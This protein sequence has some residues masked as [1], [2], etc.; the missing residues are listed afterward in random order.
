[1]D[2]SIE[3]NQK[4]SYNRNEL[5]EQENVLL[6]DKHIF[7]AING[8]HNELDPAYQCELEYIKIHFCGVVQTEPTKLTYSSDSIIYLSG[9]ISLIKPESNQNKLYV[10]KELS[11]NYINDSKDYG[12]INIGEV[13]INIHN[14]GVYFRKLFPDNIDYF[15]LIKNAHEFQTLTESNK[16]GKAFRT[17]IYLTDVTQLDNNLQFNLLRCSTNLDGPTD[18][19]RDID[20]QILHKVNHVAGSMFEKPVRLNH[21]LAQIYENSIHDK[22]GKKVEKKAVIK[23]HSDKT[24]DMPKDALI[25]FTT[26]YDKMPSKHKSNTDLFDIC[27]KS[28]SVLT[29]LYFRLKNVANNAD[30]GLV[31]EFTVTLYPNS[32]FIIPLSTNRLYTHEIRPS[33]LSVDKIPTRLGYVIRCSNTKAIFKDGQTYIHKDGDLNKL[34]DITCDTIQTIRNLYFTENVSTEIVDYPTIQCSMNSGDYKMPII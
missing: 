21:V 8:Q 17:G 9:D 1:M 4:M 19:F 18:N 25:A 32:V 5:Y 23:A 12:I 6:K 34:Q 29:R 14:V 33:T 10:V 24:K 28:T 31:K 16:D 26:F 30:T 11:Y 27:Y 7:I 13:P 15:S 22:G 2:R 20:H 3:V